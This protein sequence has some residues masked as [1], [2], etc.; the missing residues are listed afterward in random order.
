MISIPRSWS[1]SSTFR[2]DRGKRT[3]IITAKRMISGEVLKYS[4]DYASGKARELPPRAQGEVPLIEP[5]CKLACMGALGP[6]VL[7]SLLC[8]P[9]YHSVIALPKVPSLSKAPYCHRTILSP[10]RLWTG[11]MHM[12]PLVNCIDLS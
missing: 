8:A 11:C 7:T 1:R 3:Y 2:N 12:V 4:S 5:L 9:K 10:F 6:G